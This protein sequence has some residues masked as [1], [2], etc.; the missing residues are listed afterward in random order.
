MRAV[1]GDEVDD[2]GFVLEV[3]GE[4][5]PALVGLEQRRPGWSPRRTARRAALSDGT[6]VS[7]P[8][9]RLM[10]ARSSGRPSRLLRSALV[11]N[12]SISLPTWRV[13][14]RMMAPAAISASTVLPVPSFSNCDRVEEALDQADVVVGEGRD[15]SGRSS[16]SASSGRSGRPRGR[17][18]RRST[19]R[20]ST[21]KP[22]GT[23]KTLMFGWI[24][25][26]NSSNTRCWYC[27][28]VPNL[29]AWNRRS[30]S[31]TEARRSAPACVGSAATSTREPFVEEGEVAW[32]A[33]TTSLVCSTSR[34]CSAWKTWWTAVRPMFSLARPSPAMK[35][36]SSSSL[37]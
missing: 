11:T 10:V 12:S 27:I 18:R 34:L 13:M 4:V 3:A 17:T 33:S 36:A 6:P 28:S 9:A 25:R 32:L 16:R 1:G 29:A 21:S 5:D 31:Q 23:R 26:A 20:W 14:P 2:R 37:S 22:S 15:R 30:P 35:W 19:D 8:R 24:L 7:R